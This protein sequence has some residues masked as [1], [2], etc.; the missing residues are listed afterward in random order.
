MGAAKAGVAISYD[1]ACERVYGMT[2]KE[3]K[4]TH[5]SKASD[6]QLRRMEE[7]KAMHAKHE[8]A[9]PVTAGVPAGGGFG[10]GR[11]GGAWRC[12]GCD[13][14]GGWWRKCAPKA[15]SARDAA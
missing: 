8:A 10:G 3:W 2:V 15:C 13:S 4:Q 12:G 11:G 9:P 1:D 6:E 5:Q 14:C 7:T